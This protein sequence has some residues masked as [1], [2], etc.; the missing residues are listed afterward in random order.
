[1]KYLKSAA[2]ALNR[3]RQTNFIDPWTGQFYNVIVPFNPLQSKKGSPAIMRIGIYARKSVYRDNSDSVQVQVKSCRDYAK[4]MFNGQTLEFK[5]YDQDEGFSGK[6]TSRPSFQELM[7]DVRHDRLDTVM[8]YKLD[9]ISRSVKDFSDTYDTLSRHHVAFLSVKE[10]FDTSTPIGRTV[11]YILAAFAQLER[12]NTSERVADSMLALGASGKWS[13]GTLP[14]GMSSVR[15]MVGDKQHSFLVV[16]ENRIGTVKLIYDT[17]LSGMSITKLERY[18]RDNG[19]KTENGKF[20]STSQLSN[21]LSN[22]VYCSNDPEAWL[23]FSEKGYALPDQKL[24]DGTKGLMA[25][26]K[27]AQRSRHIKSDHWS[28]SIGIHAPVIPAS[29]WIR[30]QNRFGQNRMYRDNKYEIGILKGVIRCKCGAR[31]DIRTYKK[32]SSFFSYYYCSA[33]SRKGKEFCNT[34]YVKTHE[35]DGIFIEKLTEMKLDPDSIILKGPADYVNT[36]HLCTELKKT[37][38]SIQNLTAVLMENLE[39]SAASYIVSQIESLDKQKQ[40][41]EHQLRSAEQNNQAAATAS[42]IKAQIYHNICSLL[43][44]FD[45]MTYQEKN[46]LIKRTVTSCIFNGESLKIIF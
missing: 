39:S 45:Q 35:V 28:V 9:R 11:M 42:E 3:I 30:V 12:E 40:A 2:P 37:A 21:I 33:M 46:E 6:N 17:F 23:Y 26:G 7:N 18:L 29:D 24:F 31:I 41:L 10:S 34:G 14:A 43:D 15:K 38:A 27:T 1:M 8:V 5:I 32:N 13:G 20:F 4:L 36:D 19:I 25:Y 22:P 16:D 44:N